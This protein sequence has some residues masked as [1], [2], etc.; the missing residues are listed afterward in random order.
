MKAKSLLD[1]KLKKS[2][3]KLVWSICII[4]SSTALFSQTNYYPV[5]GPV[6]FGTFSP[7]MPSAWNLQI[8]GVNDYC[9]DMEGGDYLTG[10]LCHGVTSRLGFTNTITGT[11]LEDGMQLRMSQKNFVM[12]NLENE[13]LFL[14]TNGVSFKLS[15]ATNRAWMGG[16][17]STAPNFGL[18]NLETLDNGIFIRNKA[19]NHFGISIQPYQD[20]DIAYQVL[21][22]AGNE[23]NFVV[24]GNGE[25]FAR[26]YTTTMNPF[27]DYVF[28]PSYRLMPLSELRTYINVNRHLP[29]IPT[30]EEVEENGVDLGEMNRLMMEKLEE[31]TLYIL[32]LE[33]R[34]SELEGEQETTTE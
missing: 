20:K 23:I 14:K 15:G 9:V 3:L 22:A 31:M 34:I 10:T 2:T 11:T 27:P 8:H 16:L 26:K 21:N 17:P 12:E 4:S 25:V 32:E 18:L 30:A 6:A 19:A 33:E 7:P 28:A 29:N 1:V 24:K 5:S 13:D